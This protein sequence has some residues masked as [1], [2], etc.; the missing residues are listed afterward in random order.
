M[1]VDI[2]EAVV[3]G[4]IEGHGLAC[5]LWTGPWFFCCMKTN[6]S[7]D[8]SAYWSLWSTK[9]GCKGWHR[10]L[11][12]QSSLTVA[13]PLVGRTQGGSSALLPSALLDKLFV[14]TFGASL[15]GSHR[16]TV[17]RRIPWKASCLVFVFWQMLKLF[18]CLYYRDSIN[19]LL[20]EPLHVPV[21]FYD[22]PCEQTDS[23][24]TDT[25]EK[26]FWDISCEVQ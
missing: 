17:S 26:N 19:V 16:S 9:T 7:R 11:T 2:P 23:T 22:L 12:Q 5:S 25:E 24:D 10:P 14:F 4:S 18:C 8:A 20:S 3:L 13:L 21:K 1:E 15:F 6:V